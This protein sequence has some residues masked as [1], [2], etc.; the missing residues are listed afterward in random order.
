MCKNFYRFRNI[1]YIIIFNIIGLT[2]VYSDLNSVEYKTYIKSE[3]IFL[4]ENQMIVEFNGELLT[5]QF[6]GCDENGLYMMSASCKHGVICNRCKGCAV[7]GC[8]NLCRCY[9]NIEHN[10]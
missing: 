5:P 2:V 10:P 9:P 7:R 6:V 4:Y 1:L 8:Y 3:N